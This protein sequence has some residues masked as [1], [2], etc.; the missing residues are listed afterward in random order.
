MEHY[1][2]NSYSMGKAFFNNIFIKT[3]LI[4]MFLLYARFIAP[5]LPPEVHLWLDKP[6][7]KTVMLFFIAV[8]AGFSV[9]V[10]LFATIAIMVT[11]Y[12]LNRYMFKKLQ[13]DM[14]SL[15]ALNAQNNGAEMNPAWNPSG[16]MPTSMNDFDYTALYDKAALQSPPVLPKSPYYA[17][18][19]DYENDY[20]NQMRG[21][22]MDGNAVQDS[23]PS[24]LKGESVNQPGNQRY[25]ASNYGN[26]F[27]N[28]LRNYG[29]ED[30]ELIAQINKKKND[31]ERRKGARLTSAEVQKLCAN[32]GALK[33]RPVSLS[34]QE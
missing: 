19:G 27:T 31:L 20:N 25:G 7:V 33:Q 34:Y 10:A 15:G 32:M 6:T 18:D 1:L 2:S 29:I 23:T 17:A 22:E 13:E 5:Q 26:D 14:V 4:F 30:E 12:L 21:V 8:L 3:T 9:E 28:V 11:P 24:E 16:N